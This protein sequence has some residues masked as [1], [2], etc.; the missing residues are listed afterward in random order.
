MAA[1]KISLIPNWVTLPIGYRELDPENPYR[2]Q[3]GGGFI[4]AMSGNAGFTHD[5][6]SVFEAARILR[7]NRDIKFLLSGE[8][9][10]WT[11]LKEMQAACPLPNV[12]LVERVPDSELESLSLRRRHLGRSLSQGQHRR[13]G[14]EP[15]L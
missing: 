12:T 14:A 1:S 3:C 9:V 5:P 6:A 10:G 8:G 13:V 11:K 4:V 15:H 2:Q 7:D